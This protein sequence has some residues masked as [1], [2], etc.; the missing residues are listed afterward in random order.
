MS[1][2]KKLFYTNQVWCIGIMSMSD[3]RRHVIRPHPVV[4]LMTDWKL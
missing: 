2:P 4:K 1:D 3:A